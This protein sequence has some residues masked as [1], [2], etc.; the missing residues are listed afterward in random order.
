MIESDKTGIVGKKH[1]SKNEIYSLFYGLSSSKE[2]IAL[3]ENS[4]LL[5]KKEFYRVYSCCVSNNGLVIANVSITSIGYLGSLIC[6]DKN[7]NTILKKK[8]SIAIDYFG[9][10]NDCTTIAYSDVNSM[11]SFIDIKTQKVIKKIQGTIEE[12]KSYC[13][14]RLNVD[15]FELLNKKAP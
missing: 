6:F 13:S 1:K 14:G 2:G 7:G 15:I 12:I 9:I 3:Y 11:V 10:N 8:I 5:F 4:K